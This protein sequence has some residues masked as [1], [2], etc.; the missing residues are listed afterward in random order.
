MPKFV[1]VYILKLFSSTV[2]LRS[3]A[4]Y[5]ESVHVYRT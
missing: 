1:F 4:F 5:I 2:W 3:C